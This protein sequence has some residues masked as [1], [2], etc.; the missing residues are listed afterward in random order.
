MTTKEEI[1]FSEFLEIQKKLDIRIGQIVAAERIPKSKKLLKLTVIFGV[2]DGDEK[3]VVT[4]LGASIDPEDLLATLH[5]FIMN[6]KPSKMMGITS[7]DMIMVTEAEVGDLE[8]LT[9][10]VGIDNF[11]MG[12]KLL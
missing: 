9:M 12:D 11:T 3:T 8:V 4:N 6:L 7:E 5:P 2:E 10:H 1:E